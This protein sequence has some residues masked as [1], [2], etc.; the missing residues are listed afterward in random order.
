MHGHA[1]G[2]GCELAFS[3]DLVIAAEDATFALPEVGVGLSV[4]GG[5]CLA[6]QLAV[7]PARA[8]ELILLGRSI[9]AA[10]AD[11]MG[12]LTR[13][14]APEEVEDCARA[15]AG[16]LARQ[17]RR[18]TE[19]AKASIAAA[20]ELAYERS[21]RTETKRWSPPSSPPTPAPRPTHSLADPTGTDRAESRTP[22]PTPRPSEKMNVNSQSRKE[23]DDQRRDSAAPGCGKAP[24]LH[25]GA[26]LG[27]G[28][29][30]PHKVVNP[31]T[32]E[33]LMTVPNAGAA[34]VDAAVDA[35]REAF[36]G[37]AGM[38]PRLRAECLINLAA[39]IEERADEFGQLESL[40]VGKPLAAATKEIVGSADKYRYY[41][42]VGRALT[43]VVSGEYKD[44]R[45]TS[46]VRREPIG[47]VA[48]LSPWNYPMALTAW[49]IAP[50]LMAGNT[51]VLKPS[52]ETPMTAMAL[53]ELAAEH[54][55]AGVLNVITGG[56]A[57]GR[58]LVSHR[59]VGLVSLT[60][61]TTTGRAVMEAASRSLKR[62]HLELGGKAPV[63]VFDDADI[64]RLV[65]AVRVGAFWNSGQDCTAASR[66]YVRDAR[67]AELTEAIAEMAATIEP[68][69]PYRNPG[70]AMGPLI[71]AAHR[72]RVP[73]SSSAPCG[74][75]RC[76]TR[77]AACPMA[78]CVLPAERPL[79]P[80]P[81]GRN[82]PE[83][84]LRTGDNDR[85]LRGRA[86]GDRAGQWCRVWTCGLN[87]DAEHRPGAAGRP[88][89]PRRHGL[90][91]RSRADGPRDA[92][93]RVQAVGHR[94]RPSIN[95][96]EEHTELKHLA[97][98]VADA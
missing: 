57:T 19:I 80:R 85:R 29:R 97:I 18:A 86:R 13:L 43:G 69:D 81:G 6:L 31:A 53:G 12:L 82:R 42:G 93:W 64:K 30:R 92:I 49:K 60:G 16:R 88:E 4:G 74:M 20:F 5:I 17:P 39:A 15:L 28:R 71:S 48:G 79:R 35:A 46:M 26:T 62:V 96:I 61:S 94:T 73:A 52:P 87:L 59:D 95:A 76:Y 56:D 21:Y 1:V 37:W 84:D 51:V 68:E 25:R 78:R 72:E 70:A 45:I 8:N 41:A 58:H 40:D 36:E 11:A 63:I 27:R 2:A 22:L 54:L 77:A 3:C 23:L 32:D 65:A 91:Q 47:I 55:P 89:G 38:V 7:G 34:A 66:V 98:T 75:G 24:L 44:P 10:E 50:A 14:V 90:G 9:G 67:K 33:V 83:G